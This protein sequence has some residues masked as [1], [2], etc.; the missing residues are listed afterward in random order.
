MLLSDFILKS[1]QK[2]FPA[3]PG[4]VKKPLPDEKGSTPV[5]P[6]KGLDCQASP[7]R[8]AAGKAD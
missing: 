1:F 3:C 4:Q 8:S 2:A 7:V 6:G 5:H